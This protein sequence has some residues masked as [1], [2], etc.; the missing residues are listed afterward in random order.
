MKIESLTYFDHSQGWGFEN[1]EFSKLNLLVG[2]SG[3]GKTQILRA[4]LNIREFSRGLHL[5]QVDW[6]I[7][8]LDNAGGRYAWEGKFCPNP[9]S[10]SV[11]NEDQKISFE[12][13]SLDGAIIY[14]QENGEITFQ[15]E[16]LPFKNSKDILMI[17]FRESIGVDEAYKNLNKIYFFDEETQKVLLYH[18][19]ELE[20]IQKNILRYVDLRYHRLGLKW[21]LYFLKKK[22]EESIIEFARVWDNIQKDF[23]DIFPHVKKVDIFL[24]LY[25][26]NSIIKFF[27]K[28]SIIEKNH[29]Q[30]SISQEDISSGMLKTLLMLAQIYLIPDNSVVLVD[31]LENSLGVNCMDTVLE[32]IVFENRGQ[33]ILTSHHPYIINHIPYERW[34]VV[35]RDHDLIK[36]FNAQDLHLGKSKQMAYTQ[37][38]KIIENPLEFIQPA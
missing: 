3:V 28:V 31:E 16:L 9:T 12:Q 34:L 21:K 25:E 27:P 1:L 2:A 36:I 24:N 14:K 35:T 5:N 26:E 29:P 11:E 38:M 15:G 13:L 20:R 22:S 18:S 32:N 6:K 19:S 33:F 10:D 7:T 17:F 30:S 37:L 23:I 4:I 8:F